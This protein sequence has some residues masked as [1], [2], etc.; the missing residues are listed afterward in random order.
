MKNVLDLPIA[1]MDMENIISIA[2]E[3]L[4]S[5]IVTISKGEAVKNVTAHFTD[6]LLGSNLF[7]YVTKESLSTLIEDSDIL[8]ILINATQRWYLRCGSE[9]TNIVTCVAKIHANVIT[10]NTETALPPVIKRFNGGADHFGKLYA[11]NPW[12]LLLI[13]VSLSGFTQQ[14]EEALK[15]RL[16]K[17]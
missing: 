1:L 2:E 7:A 5:A 10:D 8:A 14:I 6:K 17:K 11:A 13:I 12:F 16:A 3:S 9:M 4:L 15:E